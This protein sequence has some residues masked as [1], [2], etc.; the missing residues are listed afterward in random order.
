MQFD[1]SL[2]IYQQVVTAI[3][4][5]IAAGRI[6]PG[7]KL[8]S[9]RDLAVQYRINPNT[10]ARVYQVLETE[11][12]TETRRGTGTY[13]REEPGLLADMRKAITGTRSCTASKTGTFRKR[14]I[15]TC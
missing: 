7:D 3:K 11:H 15:R 12:V 8:P 2:P 10:A 1:N 14:S 4:K 6:A 9:C 5:E 13:V